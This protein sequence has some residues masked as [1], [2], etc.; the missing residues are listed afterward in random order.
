MPEFR[1]LP[2]DFCCPYRHSCPYLEGLSTGWVWEERQHDALLT[3]DYE[4]QMEELYRQLQDEGR[5]RQ[6]QE[7]A[8]ERFRKK[9]V[10]AS[11]RSHA[12]RH[13]EAV[14]RT[15]DGRD[16]NRFSDKKHDKTKG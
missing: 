14:L 3:A 16:G 12:P 4:R 13:G 10:P 9:P 5:Q 1:D 15:D 7:I 8:L 6:E 11:L 2:A